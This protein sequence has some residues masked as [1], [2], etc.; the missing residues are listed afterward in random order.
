M[1]KRTLSPCLKIGLLIYAVFQLA[2]H[3]MEISDAVAIPICLVSIA[4]IMSGLV[5]SGWCIG[6]WKRAYKK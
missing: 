4:F 2:D 6:K 1:K 5:Y 3:L